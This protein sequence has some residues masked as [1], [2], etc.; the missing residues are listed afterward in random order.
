MTKIFLRNDLVQWI[1]SFLIGLIVVVGLWPAPGAYAAGDTKAG[2]VA[3]K[4]PAAT[5]SQE[6]ATQAAL[7]K[8]PG[9]VTDVT[10]EK[11]R[12]KNVYVIEIIADKDGEETDVLVDMHRGAVLGMEH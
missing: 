4:V 5:V 10:I 3:V 9:K 2:A 8:L 1:G 11:K 12:G 6:Q 7:Q